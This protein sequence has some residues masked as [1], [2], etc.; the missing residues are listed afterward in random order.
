M[1]REKQIEGM[2]E[3]YYKARLKARETLGSMNEGEEMWYSKAFLEAGYRKQ[4]WISVE[5]RFPE[6]ST[7]V[8]AYSKKYNEVGVYYYGGADE[9]WDNDGWASAKYYE[10]THWMPLPEAP[11]GGE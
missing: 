11:K 9:W 5:E 10:I 6:G 2:P 1:S 4:E 8:L 7:R 3:V